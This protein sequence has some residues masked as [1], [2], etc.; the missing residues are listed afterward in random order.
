MASTG[1]GKERGDNPADREPFKVHWLDSA[2]Q[3]T[4][5][6]NAPWHLIEDRI[7]QVL[8]QRVEKQFLKPERKEALLQ[9]LGQDFTDKYLPTAK[10]NPWVLEL[11]AMRPEEKQKML[12]E[13]QA[14]LNSQM[15]KAANDVGYEHMT[16]PNPSGNPP[17]DYSAFLQHT[18]NIF[19]I[20]LDRELYRQE[21]ELTKQRKH[22]LNMER[23]YLQKV[24]APSRLK[25]VSTGYSTASSGTSTKP[26]SGVMRMEVQRVDGDPPPLWGAQSDEIGKS[27]LAILQK[28]PRKFDH[29]AGRLHG[30][31]LPG[32]LRA[33]IWSDVLFK[34]E[35]KRLKEV[36]VEKVVRERF[37]KALGRGI[38]DLKINRATSSPINGLIE[39]AV[40][41]TYNKTTCLVPFKSPEHMKEAIRTL[42]VIYVYDRSYEPYLIH[43]LFPLQIAFQPQGV[44]RKDDKGEN[45]IELAMYMDLLNSNS[46]PTWPSVFAIAEKSLTDIRESDPDFYNH[47]KMISRINVKVNPKEFLVQ[48]LHEEKAKA[49]LLLQTTPGGVREQEMSAQLLADP[50]V[51][52]RRWIGEGFVSILDAPSVMYIWDQC[53]LQNWHSTVIENFVVAL[54]ELLRH[55]FMAARDYLGMKEVFLREPCKVYTIDLQQAWIHMERGNDPSDIPFLNRQ[56]PNTPSSRMSQVSYPFS[57]PEGG[58]L[59][60]CGLKDVKLELVIPS[61]VMQ[62]EPWL[63]SVDPN[64][65]KLNVV[66]YFGEVRLKSNS[67]MMPSNVISTT[68]DSYGNTIYQIVYPEDKF[69]FRDLDLAPYDLEREMGAYPYA[70]VRVDYTLIDPSSPKNKKLIPVGWARIPLFQRQHLHGATSVTS[71]DIKWDLQEGER[72]YDLHPG[73]IPD[74][75]ISTQPVTPQEYGQPQEG[76]ILGYNSKL[77]A[78]IFD[79]K[80]EP[81]G[82]FKASLP[83]QMPPTDTRKP[84]PV[85]SPRQPTPR[86]TPTPTPA[87]PSRTL[88]EAPWVPHVKEKT[89]GDPKPTGLEEPF[90][91]YIDSVRFIPDNATI[92][93]VTGRILR[94]GSVG[95]VEDILVLPDLNSSARSPTFSYRLTINMEKKEADP[96]MLAFLRVY[97]VDIVGD[98]IGVIGSCLVP[99]FD[100]KKKLRVGGFQYRLHNG[101][102]VLAQP[103]GISGIKPTDLDTIPAMP[104]SS[105]LVRIRPHTEEQAPYPQYSSGYFESS[106]C[107]PTTSEYRIFRSYGEHMAYPSSVREMIQRI[108]ETDGLP[109]HGKSDTELVDWLKNR[110]DIRQHLTPGRPA[111]DLSLLRCVRYKLKMG[112]KV[113]INQVYGMPEGVYIQCFGRVAPGAKVLS[114]EQTADGFGGEEKF[115]TLKHNFDSYQS[116]QEWTDDPTH[117]HPFYDQNSC[118][119]IQLFGLEVQYHPRPDHREPGAVKDVRGNELSLEDEDRII[120]WTVLPLFEG[121]MF[122]SVPWNSVLVGSHHVPVFK[123][124]PSAEILQ[125]LTMLPCEQ[126]L[127]QQNWSSRSK[128]NAGSMNITLWDAHFDYNDI[129]ELP[130]YEYLLEPV[131]KLADYR[132]ARNPGSGKTMNNFVLDVLET[133]YKK[134]GTNSS[135]FQKE[136]GF[137]KEIMEKTFYELME[138]ALMTS[139]YGPL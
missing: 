20:G 38:Q 65:L 96:G 84:T 50:L 19:K 25:P 36:V 136:R 110:L 64:S 109:P 53:F 129:P 92:V 137:F 122:N 112:L 91:L 79:P 49:E 100:N 78:L 35:R 130:I 98:T 2:Y 104:G 138:N 29:V 24:P 131:G 44:D 66:A 27:I 37:A 76:A 106:A 5:L 58:I 15:Y 48:L 73:E 68:Q 31:Q 75:L 59:N 57:D 17:P 4:L 105:M 47:L 51:F 14:Y 118:L 103:T 107:E 125:Q 26:N 42:N 119:V 101:M 3:Q 21:Q 82:K 54:L 56:R 127:Q 117:L 113:Q 52:I 33:Y 81:Q 95:N 67:S 18:F 74:S 80:N 124:K 16:K 115:V 89:R 39:N 12:R 8:A 128:Y 22:Q 41:E 40:I 135:I 94:T 133:K 72:T 90:D 85:P 10:R 121:N 69:I 70:I 13:A 32:S 87:P 23:K 116:A 11:P 60:P 99:F 120:G 34:E 134:Q 77:T 62:R 126:V 71:L 30:R 108:M 114:M 83:P 123:G 6:P 43:W 132:K 86:K 139:G 45:V 63:A 28:D 55:K 1:I 88:N 7:S 9:I 111:G 46:F 102:P 93:K 97:S 61:E